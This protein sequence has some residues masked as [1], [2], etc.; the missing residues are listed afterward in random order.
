MRHLPKKTSG[1]GA[2]GFPGSGSPFQASTF[3]ITSRTCGIKYLCRPGYR[4]TEKP[5]DDRSWALEATSIL[6]SRASRS[7]AS[8]DFAAVVILLTLTGTN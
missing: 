4:A 8:S 6:I 1:N 7:R 5:A 3:H 2:A